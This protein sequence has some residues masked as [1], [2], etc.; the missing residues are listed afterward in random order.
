MRVNKIS[1]VEGPV[2]AA[3]QASSKPPPRILV[4][5]DEPDIRRLNTEVLV[6]SG[7]QV[8]AAKDGVAAWQALHTGRYDLLIADNTMPEVT[9]LELIKKMNSEGMNLPVILMS[10]T[11][12]M[13][14]LRLQPWRNIRATLS[15]PYTLVE[16]LIT[17]EK[18][19]HATDD[20]SAQPV[21][22]EN[23]QSRPSAG[24]LRGRWDL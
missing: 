5:D 17:V 11:L 8:D 21:V 13:E 2:R 1:Q 20:T 7:Y 16:L 10:A 18:V 6:E 22:V 23:W 14:E 9:G 19:L 4:V 15:K 3:C 12:P 24:G